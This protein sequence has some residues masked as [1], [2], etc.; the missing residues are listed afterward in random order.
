MCVVYIAIIASNYD[1]EVLPHYWRGKK[2]KGM[3]SVD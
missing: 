2:K 3:N 1:P